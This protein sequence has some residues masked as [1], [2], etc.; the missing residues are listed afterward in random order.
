VEKL[1]QLFQFFSLNQTPK[2]K[3]SV[4]CTTTEWTEEV[5]DCY[6]FTGNG[7]AIAAVTPYVQSYQAPKR[8]VV[9]K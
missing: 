1:R 7:Q 3:I 2:I 6:S 5:Q 9:F 8:Q 4:T